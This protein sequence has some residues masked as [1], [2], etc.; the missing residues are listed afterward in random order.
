M[1]VKREAILWTYKKLANGEHEIRIRLTCYKDVKYLG[2]EF[3][4]S[5]E[6][7]DDLNHCPLPTHPQYKKIISKI[8]KTEDDIDFEVKLAERNGEEFLPMA[9][10]KKRVQKKYRK[11][12][13]TTKILSFFDTVIKE[14]DKAGRTGYADAFTSTKSTVSKVLKG[15]DKSFISFGKEDAE[16][17]EEALCDGSLE[18]TS[19]SFYLRTFYRLWNIAID[20]KV[21]PPNHHPK[22]FIRFKAYKKI[23][24]RK[25]AVKF[26][27]IKALE[28]ISYEETDF[29][30]IAQKYFLFIYYA[31][32]INFIDVAKVKKGDI[33]GEYIHY[34]RSKSGR[35]YD[36]KLHPKALAI[37]EFFKEYSIQSDAGYVFPVLF[38]QHD[39]PRKIKS[40]VHDVL[41]KLNKA[42]REIAVDIKSPKKITS[43]VMRHSIASNLRQ[44]GTATSIIQEVLG[45]ETDTETAIYLDSIEDDI[46]AN[47]IERA[48]Q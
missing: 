28:D 27:Y 47:E 3:S 42:F 30:F 16:R 38:Q 48:L 1:D 22:K 20:E 34:K 44:N 40:R 35:M 41:G 21:C 2:I 25:R 24:T 32:G 39:T 43:Y 36:F 9:E 37:I 31:R 19:I 12:L 14:F 46:V 4:S 23:K 29:K 11:K 17:Y 45:H 13:P 5:I 8:E 33:E 26:D 7:W 15:K 10:L 18:D 6:D